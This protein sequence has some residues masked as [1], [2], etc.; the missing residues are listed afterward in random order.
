M[1]TVRALKACAGR[2]TARTLP[3]RAMDS[4]ARWTRRMRAVVVTVKAGVQ[5][6][7]AARRWKARMGMRIRREVRSRKVRPAP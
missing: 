5:K 6:A 3:A 2:S 7:S 1:K 4:V